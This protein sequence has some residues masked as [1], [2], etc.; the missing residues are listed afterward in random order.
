[1]KYITNELNVKVAK[2]ELLKEL[3]QRV[4][5]MSPEEEA[6]FQEHPA[7]ESIFK[8]TLVIMQSVKD[9]LIESNF[10][11]NEEKMNRVAKWADHLQNEYGVVYCSIPF[12]RVK[13]ISL[14]SS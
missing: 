3:E 5:T 14:Y 1:M 9:N 7:F 6:E 2:Q 11:Q 12:S 4:V 13:G 10:S 8:K